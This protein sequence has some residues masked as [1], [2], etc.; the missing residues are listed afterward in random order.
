[1]ST[2]KIIPVGQCFEYAFQQA[3][4]SL[5][6]GIENKTTICHA[7]IH[8]VWDSRPYCHAWIEQDEKVYDW[9]TMV[10]GTSKWGKVGWDKDEFY[11]AFKPINITRFTPEELIKKTIKERNKGPFITV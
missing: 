10:V 2:E 11:E 3:I 8:D 4:K 6:E 5:S 7:T 1:M 9:Q